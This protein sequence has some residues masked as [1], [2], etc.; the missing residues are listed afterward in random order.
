MEK[1]FK[2]WEYKVEY[3]SSVA[4]TLS[5]NNPRDLIF[6]ENYAGHREKWQDELEE[7]LTSFGND[8]WELVQLSGS[9]LNFETPDG[10]CLFKREKNE[11]EDHDRLGGPLS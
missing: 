11:S 9:L 1:N 5:G 7:I 10:W 6:G 2:K 3:I 4:C 8:G